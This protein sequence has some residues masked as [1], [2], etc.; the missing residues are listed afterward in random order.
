MPK[1]HRPGAMKKKDILKAIK[2]RTYF[3]S[4]A[5]QLTSASSSPSH[6][7]T[8][9]SDGEDISDP[10]YTGIDQPSEGYS[11]DESDPKGK[12]GSSVHFRSSICLL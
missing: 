9:S 2:S 5:D 3:R 11:P 1:P 8:T 10:A 7:T 6:H 12:R 4:A